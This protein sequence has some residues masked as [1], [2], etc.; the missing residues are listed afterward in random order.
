M[1]V[2]VRNEATKSCEQKC[3]RYPTHDFLTYAIKMAPRQVAEDMQVKVT[4][5][6]FNNKGWDWKGILSSHSIFTE[7]AT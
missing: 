7:D 3:S 2:L 1:C 4:E 5:G 6:G